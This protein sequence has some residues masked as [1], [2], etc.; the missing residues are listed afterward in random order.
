MAQRCVRVPVRRMAYRVGQF[1]RSVLAYSRGLSAAEW[2]EVE[3]VLPEQARPLFRA[4]PRNDQRHSLN[5]LRALRARGYYQP[6]LLQAA[7]L[8]DTA[9]S[10]AGLTLLHRTVIVLLKAYRPALL[11]R[12]S[13]SPRTGV[14]GWRRPFQA[15]ACHASQGATMAAASGCDPLTCLL[16]RHHQDELPVAGLDAATMD[17]LAI[18]QQADDSQ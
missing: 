5:V 1:A 7:L 12:W 9:K 3:A 18:L 13:H 11:N 10:A 14:G 6:S 2:R 17:L 4:M 8:H 15:Y 16:V